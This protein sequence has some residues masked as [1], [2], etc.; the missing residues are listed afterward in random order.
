[1]EEY[2]LHILRKLTL[3]N[4]AVVAFDVKKCQF[5]TVTM[6]YI[7]HVVQPKCPIFASHTTHAIR[8][9][10]KPTIIS[11][12]QS[13]LVPCSVFNRFVSTWYKSIEYIVL[14]LVW[15]LVE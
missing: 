3:L 6:D 5:F 1:M 12:L 2:I 15:L 9:H 11:K 7:G 8:G 14:Y 4:H 10:H 13:F